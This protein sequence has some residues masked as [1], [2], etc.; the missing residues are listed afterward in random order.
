MLL[1]STVFGQNPQ[2]EPKAAPQQ[3]PPPKKLTV[4]ADGHVSAN[5]DPENPGQFE[6]HVVKQGETLSQIS[7]EVL[8]NSRLWP[9]LWE[10]NEHIINPH[11]IY[12]ND[13]IL[14]RPITVIAEAKPPEPEPAPPVAEQ[15]APRRLAPVQQA[16]PTAPPAPAAPTFVFEEQKPVSEVKFEDLYCSGFLRSSPLPK[17]L[18]VIGKFDASGA[19]IAAEAD[20]VYL[21]QG[22]EQGIAAG[23]VYQAVRPT[24]TVTNPNGRT[25]SERDLGM[26]Y[27]EVAQLRVVLAQSDVSL[28]RVIHSCGDAVEV[29]DILM[30]FKQIVLPARDRSRPFSPTMTTKS[31]VKGTIVTTKTVLLN[32]GSVFKE[33]GRASCRERV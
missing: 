11:W 9:Q 1:A 25:K 6:L 31:G 8:K 13:K 4:R 33:I 28:A 26:H 30:P 20:Y 21:S 12:P 32:F 24:R 19:V 18:K 15:T 29:G 27:L 10:Q 23:N 2:T 22:S 16:P 7:G 14:I 17:D 5:D 3:G